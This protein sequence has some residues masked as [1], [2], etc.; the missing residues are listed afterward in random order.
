MGLVTN[1]C[2]SLILRACLE[3]KASDSC[4]H[5]H[6]QVILSHWDVFILFPWLHKQLSGLEDD[7]GTW[8]TDKERVD[9]IPFRCIYDY[10]TAGDTIRIPCPSPALGLMS[11][12]IMGM[13]LSFLAKPSS[14]FCNL[15]NNGY[16]LMATGREQ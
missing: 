14:F 9:S 5:E 11:E 10:I 1:S 16:V 15:S 13:F 2:R 8:V 12:L 4:A 3:Y 7:F 6:F